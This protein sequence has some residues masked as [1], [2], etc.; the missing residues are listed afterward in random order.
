MPKIQK[1]KLRHPELSRAR[2]TEVEIEVLPGQVAIY[3]K[4]GW[5]QIAEPVTATSKK[6]S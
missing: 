4:S 6:E 1:V 3:K 5:R 2:K